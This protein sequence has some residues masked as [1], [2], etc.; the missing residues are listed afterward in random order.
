MSDE[1]RKVGR[2]SFLRRVIGGA[3]VG[4]VAAVTLSGQAEARTDHDSTDRIGHGR[5]GRRYRSG[6]TDHDQ[7][8]SVGHGRGRGHR[9][10]SGC[11]D[12][13]SGDAAGRGRCR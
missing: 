5:G 1:L 12:R 2:R 7:G 8:D 11:T 6:I 10:R 3:V 4:T 9:G 13:D